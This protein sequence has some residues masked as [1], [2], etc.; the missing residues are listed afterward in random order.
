[1]EHVIAPNDH[2]TLAHELTRLRDEA[3]RFGKDNAAKIAA[4]I[5][6]WEAVQ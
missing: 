5:R 1:M 6:A 4:V 2:G 3:R